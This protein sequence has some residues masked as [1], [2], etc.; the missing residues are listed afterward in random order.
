MCVGS[1]NPSAVVLVLGDIGRSPRMQYQARSLAE[2]LGFQ[3]TI[4]GFAGTQ[5]HPAVLGTCEILHIPQFPI[6]QNS[7]I[8]RIRILYLGLKF[9]W[10]S[11]A[12]LWVL[13][14]KISSI[15]LLVVQTPP[16]VPTLIIAAFVKVWTKCVV[17]VDWHNFAHSVVTF[18]KGT[19][20]EKSLVARI[21]K[22]VEMWFGRCAHINLSVT[23]AMKN[24]LQNPPWNLSNVTTLYDKPPDFFK[25]CE[26]LEMHMLMQKFESQGIFKNLGT[27]LPSRSSPS[28]TILTNW[29]KDDPYPRL[30]SDRPFLLVS[31]T[32][33][34][35]DEDFSILLDALKSLET[36]CK[37]LVMVTGM[38]P[39]KEFYSKKITEFHSSVENVR[40]LQVWLDP[41]DYP[42]ILGTANLGVS[43]HKSTSGVDLPM[44][45]VDMF[46]CNLPV[47]AYKFPAIQELVIDGVNGLTFGNAAELSLQVSKLTSDFPGENG[48]LNRLVSGVENCAT[49]KIR[50][51]ANWN[52]VVKPLLDNC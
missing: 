43:L 5:P 30:R 37:I 4:V 29:K 17:C 45:I 42:K 7:A 49:N 44:K 16:A 52:E 38:G 13:L 26:I 35:E 14:W 24:Q 48:L 51:Q 47:C 15:Q 6:S 3:V 8:G 28:D 1:Q 25:K 40:I 36:K 39:L 27:F 33:Y 34:T 18:N 22:A 46:G 31:S 50:W 12:L 19:S 2:S 9:I 21:T 10:L 41:P 11:L 23:D 32:S 20:A